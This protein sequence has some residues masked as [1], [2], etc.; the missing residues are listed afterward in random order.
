M[1]GENN[2]NKPVHITN[3]MAVSAKVLVWISAKS[4]RLNSMFVELL[5]GTS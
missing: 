5:T 3:R 4:G 1:V 2:F